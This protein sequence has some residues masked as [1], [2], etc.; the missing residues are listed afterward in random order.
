MSKG[1]GR[2]SLAFLLSAWRRRRR[3]EAVIGRQ[4]GAWLARHGAPDRAAWAARLAEL[5]E[6]PGISVVMP[7]HETRPDWLEA[8]I[9]SVRAQI[10]GQWE[11]LIT[12]DASASPDVAAILA[13]AAAA[14]PRIDVARLAAR[15]GISAASNHALARAGYDYVAFLD[16]DDLLAPHA[17]A[18][19]ACE[20]AAHPDTDLVFSDEDQ[21]EGGR[22]LRPYF[23]P[24]WNPDLLLA[25]NLVCHLAVYRRALVA[26]L[27][28]LRPDFDGSQ[29]FDLALRA[30]AQTGRI[31][32]VPE[33]LYHWRQSPGSF[34]AASA[35]ACRDA[36]RRAIAAALAPGDA[37]AEDPALPW[38]VVRFGLEDAPR[39]SVIGA[40]PPAA[41]YPPAL[42]EHVAR[43]EAAT[44]EVL[45]FLA[46]GLAPLGAD[47]LEA[48]V[49]PLR[50]PGLGAAGARLEWRSRL[51]HA[52]YVLDPE[53]VAQ[54]PAPRADEAD[55]GY[56]GQFRLARTVSA[57]SGD[58]L[59]VRRDAFL[60]AGG[61]ARDAGD[62]AAVDLCLKLAARGLRTVWVPRA[63]LRHAARPRPMRAGAAWMKA[64]WGAALAADPYQNPH[65]RL[66]RG[67]ISLRLD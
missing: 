10:H 27:G 31:R 54:S 49:A 65:L 51:V 22:R 17:L 41:A 57:V 9:A 8:A 66:A 56:R 60:A 12:D 25:Q 1:Q 42:I 64:R 53:A 16:H 52:G 55:P 5:P 59:A 36:A 47:W 32:H 4:Y 50:R 11:L 23:K 48:L 15:S 13:R 44:G 2:S 33:V 45:L 67:R 30:A 24:G 63:A 43:P 18:C 28:G 39:L 7:V 38:P 3:P 21:L 6:A 58:C 14:D 19:M 34:S 35:A 29:D 46:P 37:V 61:F 20:L 26:R 40:A 62:F